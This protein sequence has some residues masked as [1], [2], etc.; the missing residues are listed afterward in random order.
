M[1][2]LEIFSRR[3]K[4][5]RGEFPDVYQYAEL[6][7]EFR[8]QMVHVLRDV[9]GCLDNIRT[10]E[11]FKR[12]HDL[13]CREYGA[14]T[15]SEKYIR[16]FDFQNAVFDFLLT[17]PE[18]EKALDVVELALRFA[19]ILGNDWDFRQSARPIITAEAAIQE[20]NHRFKDHGIGFYFE[21]REIVRVDSQLLHQEVVRPALLFL[22]SRDYEGPNKEFLQ[23]HE[24][25]R[26]GRLKE[27][28]VEA[29]KALES[30]LKVIAARRKWEI[31]ESATAKQ[32]LDVA[33][34]E[35]FIPVY[36]QSAF[37]GLRS[38]LE[39]GVPTIRNKIAG[40]GQGTT[41]ITVPE[42]LAGYVLHLTAS[43]IVF[44]VEA[45]KA[46]AS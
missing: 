1:P 39:A 40:H 12:I 23:A 2:I 31:Q 6:P 38:T 37:S 41:L 28:I 19:L 4:E 45:D 44:V 7:Q 15:L 46:S 32:L 42:Y 29:A 27:A 43:A 9:L 22:S 11:T 8:I 13:L 25:Y 34:R 5:V 20:V 35:S 14:F 3:Q 33:F 30:T 21:G 24:H 18:V 10:K 17:T 16:G 26:N 36:L